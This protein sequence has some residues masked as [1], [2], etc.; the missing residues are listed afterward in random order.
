[1]RAGGLHAAAGPI[2][3]AAVPATQPVGSLVPMKVPN[4]SNFDC[5]NNYPVSTRVAYNGTRSIIL[6][7]VTAIFAGQMDTI[8]QKIG[9]EFDDVMFDLNRT[10]FGDPLRMDDVLDN[11]GKIIMLFSPRVNQFAG[12]IG[13]VVNCDFETVQTSPASNRAE[14]F[15]SV[16]PTDAGTDTLNERTRPGWYRNIRSTII[17]E[18]KHISSFAARIRDFGNISEERWIEEGSAR[19]AEEIWARTAAYN[20]MLQKSNADY[21]TTVF[22]DRRPSLP[23]A[24]ECAGKP[25]VMGRHFTNYYGFL[26]DPASHSPLGPR[27]GIPDNSWYGSAWSM[28]RW[29]VDHSGADE[30]TFF[31]GLVQTSQTGV[32]NLVARVGR[33]WE[34]ILGEW[35]L[36]QYVDDL[37]GFVPANPRLTFPSWDLRSIYFGS[38]ADRPDL[39]PSTYPLIPRTQTFGNFSVTV[40]LVHGGGFAL[41]ELSG[42]QTGRQLVQ[43]Q[44]A[45]GGDPSAKLRIAIVRT[46]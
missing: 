25:F 4:I 36:T 41:F 26:A 39:F 5:A 8:Y 24:P 18:L 46:N 2:A 27:L 16:V 1:M 6:E 42:P 11:N 19:L 38:N 12:I 44:G 37:P 40:P 17:H 21:G 29:A 30:A 35:S 7:D 32:A 43:L 13:F 22:C 34:E 3:L 15:Y 10:T 9:R 20:G 45:N 28:L 14:V 23:S 31:Q 33:P